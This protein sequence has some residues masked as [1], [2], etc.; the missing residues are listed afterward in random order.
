MAMTQAERIQFLKDV[1]Q[2]MK[3][4][5]GV[6]FNDGLLPYT[7]EDVNDELSFLTEQEKENDWLSDFFVDS[8]F[9]S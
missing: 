8:V 4:K 3:L 2:T 1:H 6:R 9:N 7:Q 5:N